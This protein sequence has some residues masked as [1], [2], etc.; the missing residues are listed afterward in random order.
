M[1]DLRKI[2]FRKRRDFIAGGVALFVTG[3]LTGLGLGVKRSFDE[4]RAEER[5]IEAE[6]R[7]KARRDQVKARWTR[8]FVKEMAVQAGKLGSLAGEKLPDAEKFAALC[9]EMSEKQAGRLTP[10]E[11]AAVMAVSKR[12]KTHWAN[13]VYAFTQYYNLWMNLKKPLVYKRVPGEL[14]VDLEEDILN[15]PL[16]L[17]ENDDV[18]AKLLAHAMYSPDSLDFHETIE[19]AQRKISSSSPKQ[20]AHVRQE[21]VHWRRL[22]LSH[23]LAAFLEQH[24]YYYHLLKEDFVE[25]GPSA[26]EQHD[27]ERRLRRLHGTARQL[28]W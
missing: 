28:S 16:H 11:A 15:I 21:V 19:R 20:F 6:N 23:P 7:E 10:K 22:I 13:V 2:R 12:L 25:V 18:R 26:E 3:I 5:R 27:N 17:E 8:D 14:L 1:A 9:F 4:R 24:P